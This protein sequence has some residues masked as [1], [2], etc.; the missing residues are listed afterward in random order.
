[1]IPKNKD[2]KCFQYV[3]RVVLNHENIENHLGK[4]QRLNLLLINTIGKK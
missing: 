3:V 4:Y 1:M 2:N